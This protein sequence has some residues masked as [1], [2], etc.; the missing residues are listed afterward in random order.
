MK[1]IELLGHDMVSVGTVTLAVVTVGDHDEREAM[2][3]VTL[4]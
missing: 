1:S 3:K 2:T 4:M